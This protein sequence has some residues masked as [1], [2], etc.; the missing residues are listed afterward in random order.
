MEILDRRAS[1][2]GAENLVSSY[3]IST[4]SLDTSQLL[5]IDLD[6]TSERR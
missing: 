2:E 5:G 3:P 1:T 6:E 4:P